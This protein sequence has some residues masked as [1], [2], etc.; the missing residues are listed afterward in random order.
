MRRMKCLELFTG[1]GGLAMG[2]G[3]AGFKHAGV[4]E[5]DHDACETMR[6]NKRLKKSP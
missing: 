3:K 5:Y 6:F 4:V 1:A 2:I